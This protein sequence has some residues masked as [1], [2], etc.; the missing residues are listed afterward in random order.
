MDPMNRRTQKRTKKAVAGNRPAT[1]ATKTILLDKYP[2][3]GNEEDLV[4]YE[5]E[6]PVRFSPADTD[7]SAENY[8]SPSHGDGPEDNEVKNDD[9]PLIWRRVAIWRGRSA[10]KIFFR[11]RSAAAR[12][13]VALA[14]AAPARRHLY[15]CM[16]IV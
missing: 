13:A 15:E 2:S 12:Q 8:D 1:K 9:F 3:V 4:D 5:P 7:Y 6:E 11:R 16:M 14:S 10:H